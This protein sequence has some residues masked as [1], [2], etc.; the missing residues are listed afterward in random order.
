MFING[1]TPASFSPYRGW[2]WE[3]V[4]LH[5]LQC[6]YFL[7]DDNHCIVAQVVTLPLILNGINELVCQS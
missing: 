4:Y 1:E 7:L 2:K 3:D 5:K 6:L